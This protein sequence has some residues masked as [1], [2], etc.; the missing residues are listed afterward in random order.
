MHT[1]PEIPNSAQVMINL[2]S[3]DAEALTGVRAFSQSSTG[4]IGAE[5]AA[6]VRGATDAASKRELAILRRFAKGFEEIGRKFMSMNA[7]FLDKEEIIRITNDEF[8]PVRKDDLQGNFD[9]RLSISTAEANKSKADQL[10]FMLQTIG[11]TIGSGLSKTVISEIATLHKMPALA[12]KI[13][14]YQEPPNPLAEKKAQLEI[15]LLEAQIYNETAKGNE[16]NAN[17]ALD[18]AKARREASTAD[19]LDLDHVE[20]AEGVTQERDK[21]LMGVQARGNMALEEKKHI[22]KLVESQLAPNKGAK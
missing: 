7:V 15:Q 8:I 21:E 19:K 3:A 16:N 9:L 17:A 11:Q 12:R 14:E 6:G 13:E 1:Y 5:T 4:N 20:Q 18:N 10:A 2:Q 22:N